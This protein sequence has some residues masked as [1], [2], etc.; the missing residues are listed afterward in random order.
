MKIYDLRS[1]TITLPSKEMRKE[2]YRADVGDDVYGEDPTVNRLQ[3]LACRITGKKAALFVSSG[4]M[5]NLIPLYILCG[6][7]NEVLAQKESH[8]FHYELSSSAAIAG[9][10]PVAVPGERG[11]LKPENMEPLIRKNIYYMARTKMIEIEN[12]H[13]REGGTCYTLSELKEVHDFAKK[14]S[15]YIHLDG[16]R[17]FNASIATG[18]SVKR[19]C[20]CSDTI[21]FC[22]SKGLGAPV[23]SILC[24][25]KEF[26][27]EAKRVRKLLGGGMRQIGMLAEAGIY[28]LNNNIERLAQDHENAKII[29]GA[30]N[31][32]SWAEVDPE[33]T[34]T[35]IFFFNT[36]G[37]N[38]ADIA[39][40]L[41]KK[42]ILCGADGKNRI[43]IVTSMAVSREDTGEICKII[44]EL[45]F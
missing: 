4:S 24:G 44:R 38:A 41:K 8:L 21:T 32:T 22:L 13:N 28:A 6:R 33:K 16:A 17:I 45:K 26:I 5:G 40:A 42:D 39:H 15:L 29:A 9:V 2:M 3:D 12:T 35:N 27:E 36:P 30:I 23:G 34:E 25:E 19:I 10:L 43:R 7:G 18:I 1:D 37:S 20:S 14:H 11:I 31:Q